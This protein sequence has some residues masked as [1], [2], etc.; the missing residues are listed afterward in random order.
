[1]GDDEDSYRPKWYAI[2]FMKCHTNVD[3]SSQTIPKIVLPTFGQI[4]A[5][6]SF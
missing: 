5:F 6:V 2:E 1:M 4:R 3:S